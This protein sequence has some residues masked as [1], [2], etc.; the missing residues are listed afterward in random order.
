[1]QLQ[2][3]R[4]ISTALFTPGSSI[5]PAAWGRNGTITR[6]QESNKQSDWYQLSG[7]QLSLTEHSTPLDVFE[8]EDAGPKQRGMTETQRFLGTALC[9]PSVVH[10]FVAFA[11]VWRCVGAKVSISKV[12]LERKKQQLKW[13]TDIKGPMLNQIFFFTTNYLKNSSDLQTTAWFSSLFTA[14][15]GNCGF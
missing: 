13:V 2:Q 11:P 12:A 6:E 7:D 8:Q 4:D 5:S 3:Q 9:L 14:S 1:M 10:P 15:N